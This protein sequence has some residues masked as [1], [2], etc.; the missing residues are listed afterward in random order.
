MIDLDE[1]NH[2]IELKFQLTMEWFE[3]RATYQNLKP[4][5]ALNVLSS[6]ELRQIWIPFIIF[7]VLHIIFII[8]RVIRPTL[9]CPQQNTD[10]NEVVTLDVFDSTVYVNREGDFTRADIS[11]VDEVEIFEGKENRITMV[12]TYSKR[13]HCTYL[14][15][16][17]PFDTQVRRKNRVS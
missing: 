15:H 1:R 12:Q 13:F 9:N 6:E 7:K 10:L 4:N 11:S 3:Y 16:N 14:L 2:I 8:A 5:N 17:F